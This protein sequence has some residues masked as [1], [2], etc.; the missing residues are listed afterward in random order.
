MIGTQDGGGGSLEEGTVTITV[1]A[2]QNTNVLRVV[3][4]S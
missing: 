2:A 1:G 4:K 3:I